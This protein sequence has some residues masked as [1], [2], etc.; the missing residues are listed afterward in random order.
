MAYKKQIIPFF[1]AILSLFDPQDLR[2]SYTFG[3]S[4][5]R[6][7]KESLRQ[8]LYCHD[9]LRSEDFNDSGTTQ[10]FKDKMTYAL[11]DRNKEDIKIISLSR[12]KMT[13]DHFNLVTNYLL[14]DLPESIEGDDG[15]VAPQTK[16][17]PHLQILDL[18]HNKINIDSYDNLM[19]WYDQNPR[20][21]KINVLATS[22]A[23]KNVQGLAEKINDSE[24][25]S[26]IIF[27]SLGYARSLKSRIKY[28]Q[29]IKVY[30]DLEGQGL[31]EADWIDNTITYYTTNPSSKKLK[32]VE[33]IFKRFSM[34][35]WLYSSD[36][37]PKPTPIASLIQKF[38][39]LSVS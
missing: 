3:S 22:M 17:F 39:L 16:T 8:T 38:T 24:K 32:S 28:D 4:L 30:Q 1:F 27:T 18:G 37:K 33:D 15:D 35:Q 25:M 23:L 34:F 14:G 19:R 29:P 9:I 21:I 13:N 10:L 2:A 12:N 11:G 36:P 6:D 31:L 26:H 5:S 20:D 7:D